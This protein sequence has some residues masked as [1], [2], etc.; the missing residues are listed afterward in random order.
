MNLRIVYPRM[1]PHF[2]V[3]RKT[4]RF[5]KHTCYEHRNN[6]YTYKSATTTYYVKKHVVDIITEKKDYESVA[7]ICKYL[8]YVFGSSRIGLKMS[9]PLHDELFSNV[10]YIK[11]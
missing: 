4:R 5:F 1:I 11:I 6:V 8:N 9:E 10:N 7:F 2:W 3:K